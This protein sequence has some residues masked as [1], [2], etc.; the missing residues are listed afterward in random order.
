MAV[1][2]CLH[3]QTELAK[4]LEQEGDKEGKSLIIYSG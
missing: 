4:I 1:R 3:I 2:K